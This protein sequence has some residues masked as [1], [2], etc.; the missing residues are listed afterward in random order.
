MELRKD[1]DNSILLL[2]VVLTCL[3]VVMVYSASSIMADKRYADGFF[4]LK[5]QGGFALTG[6]LIMAIVS[7]IDYRH[8]RKVASLMFLVSIGLLVA[9]LQG[10]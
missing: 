5:R 10:P 9:V 4:F 2:S 1:F 6:F 7:Q 3:G 8:Y